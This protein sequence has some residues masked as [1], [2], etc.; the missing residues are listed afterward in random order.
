MACRAQKK[1]GTELAELRREHE[2]MQQLNS[3]M[4]QNRREL[5]ATNEQLRHQARTCVRIAPAATLEVFSL[6]SVSIRAD[7]CCNANGR[8][9]T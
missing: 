9:P 1:A 4:L 2:L 6:P 7:G 3:T 5:N 8:L